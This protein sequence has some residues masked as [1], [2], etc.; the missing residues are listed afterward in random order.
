MTGRKKTAFLLMAV[1][2]IGCSGCGNREAFQ[3]QEKNGDASK[4][5]EIAVCVREDGSGTREEFENYLGITT[6]E[7]GIDIY[8]DAEYAQIIES[9]EAV[10]ESVEDNASA[11]GYVSVG[12]ISAQ[13][14][15]LSIDGMVCSKES[16][17]AGAYPLMRSFYLAW[18]GNM[19]DLQT[20]FLRYVKGAGQEIVGEKYI[21]VSKATS[22]LSDRNAKGTLT[23]GGSS[24]VAP[25]LQELAENYQKIN[26]E[27]EIVIEVSDSTQGLTDMLQGKYD[28]AIVSRELKDYEK[29]LAEYEEIAKDGI[30][31]IV[32]IE[33]PINT[34][35]KEE[36]QKVYEGNRKNWSEF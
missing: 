32:N 1:L 23:M 36:I 6:I 28:F 2:M 3:T 21:A 10:I 16:I 15:P 30:A 17:E 9:S 7:N 11:I 29:E 25:L 31:V 19:S 26:P 8:E 34:M 14:K 13:V 35:T 24:S 22:F 27:A 18:S 12:Q 33:N 5:G 20:D 4:L